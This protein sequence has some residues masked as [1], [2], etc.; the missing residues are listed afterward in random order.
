MKDFL[1][2]LLLIV[3]GLVVG[4]QAS[5]LIRDQGVAI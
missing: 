4:A 3:V 5:G 1:I 2:L